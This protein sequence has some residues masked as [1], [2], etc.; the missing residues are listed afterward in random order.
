[1]T[2]KKVDVIIVGAGPSGVSAAKILANNNK[3]VL[4][5][6]RGNDAG[7]KNMFG[8]AIYTQQTNEIF[9]EFWKSAPIERG[10]S[11]QK[12]FM[13]TDKESNE[14]SNNTYEK[15]NF[16][17]Y[18][19]NRAKWDKWCIEEVIK[20]GGYYAPKTLVKELIVENGKVIGIQTELEK[21]YANLVI[22]ADGVNSLLAKQLGL[23]KEIKDSD[24]TLNVKEVIKLPKETIEN[25]FNLEDNNGCGGK[26]LGG[27][28]KDMFA[29]GFLYTNKDSIS[30]GFGVGLDDLK[31]I[32]KTPYELLDELKNHPA[33]NKYINGGETIEYSAHMIPEGG[34]NSIP[35]LY[36]D[37]ALIVG[38]AAMFVNNVH[39]EG[40]NLAM[41]SGKLAAE[42]AI[43]AIDKNDFSKKTL[44]IY[45]KKI[46]NSIIYKD[47]KTH[48]NT[49]KVLKK[50]I[51]TLTNLYPELIG[52]F[53]KLIT[54]AD[55]IDKKTKYLSFVKKIIT[56][57]AI[58]KTIPLAIMAM[59]KCIKR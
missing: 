33:I 24:V 25:R 21:Y 35:Q 32:K 17:A 11:E 13:L 50:N 40:T 8:G 48:K 15:T 56:T 47:L 53:I 54:D 52:D 14:I 12:I 4:I 19:V 55:G 29:L 27:P 46:K 36:T 44:S 41:L 59:G 57:G 31:K 42:T 51:K 16:K 5:V 23:R 30:I 9:P 43:I 10:I 58:F 22:I 1:M 18:S 49:I 28:L 37:G 39:M 3:K 45:E 7:D 38:D 6:D 34:F 20:E 26:I 2:N